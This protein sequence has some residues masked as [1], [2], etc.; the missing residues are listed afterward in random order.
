M[1]SSPVDYNALGE[2]ALRSLRACMS[3][4]QLSGLCIMEALGS[5]S[6]LVI[7]D[8]TARKA[9]IPHNIVD[10]SK[11]KDTAFAITSQ[12]LSFRHDVV[13]I[14]LHDLH[15]CNAWPYTFTDLLPHGPEQTLRGYL[16][17]LA[18]DDAS[19]IGIVAQAQAP[20]RP[21][22]NRVND[23]KEKNK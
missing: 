17:W 7:G 8:Q 23:N 2:T 1:N 13:K 3:T 20:T 5:L 14:K 11:G 10:V 4:P 22:P 12:W 19:S 9:M 6:V 15:F 18:G 16:D 21:G